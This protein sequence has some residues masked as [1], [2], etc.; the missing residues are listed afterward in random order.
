[1]AQK[2]PNL[3][4]QY[5]NSVRAYLLFG[6]TPKSLW[7]LN[8]KMQKQI[9]FESCL[10]FKGFKSFGKNLINSPKFYLLM[11]LENMNLD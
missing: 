7:I 8:Y 6:P 1:M 9:Q 5:I 4:W 10:N 3:S 2:I 11:I